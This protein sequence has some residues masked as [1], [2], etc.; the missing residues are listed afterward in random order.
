MLDT[1]RALN[2]ESHR[3]HTQQMYECISVWYKSLRTGSRNR[4]YT[5]K[6]QTQ[7]NNQAPEQC[8]SKKPEA[9]SRKRLIPW[10][11]SLLC[12]DFPEQ[13]L[14]PGSTCLTFC[15]SQQFNFIFFAP[16]GPNYSCRLAPGARLSRWNVL[17][18][19]GSRF[20]E[21]PK[22]GARI[23]MRIMEQKKM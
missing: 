19:F 20:Y 5:P 10:T 22:V 8:C 17:T 18:M 1:R 23:R 21:L 12:Y 4:K 7:V 15:D 3:K 11:C 13:I 14:T 16:R 2:L 6:T 9:D